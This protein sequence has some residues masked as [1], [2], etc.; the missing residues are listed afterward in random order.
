MFYQGGNGAL[1]AAPVSIAHLLGEPGAAVVKPSSMQNRFGVSF[2]G[3][4]WIPGL[5]KANPKQFVFVNVTGMRNINPQVLNGTVPTLAERGGDFSQLLST[6]GGVTSGQ[7]F[8]PTTGLPILNNNLKNATTP[9]SPQAQALLNYYP[10][11]N[12]PG[13]GPRNNYQ[14]V[15]NAGQNSTSAALRFVRNF[16]QTSGFG[17]GGGGGGRR[18]AANAPKT[19]RQ[20]INFNGSY[21][22]AASDIRNIFLPLGGGSVSNGYGVTA[23]YTIG[24][25]RLTNNAS[26]NWNRSHAQ[27]R[28]Y[29]TDGASDP[30]DATGISIPKPV[31]GAEP[32]IFYGIPSLTIASFTGLNQTV[33]NDTINQT[34]SF[35]D[36]VSYGY[37]KHNMRF[38]L[39]FR[40]VHADSIGGNNGTGSFTFTGYATQNPAAA[41]TTDNH[42]VRSERVSICRHAARPA[43]AVGDPGGGE[44]DVPA[45]EYLRL[46]CAG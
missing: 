28:N 6:T 39:D 33:A 32:G 16:G 21:S 20:N 40:R 22:H 44:Q 10:A 34:I 31:I 14:T 9:L 29:F 8:D 18:Q 11:P 38:G 45:C 7:L 15:T 30:L 43:A 27:Q 42:I 19:L 3:S 25:G 46:V 36:F 5:Y 4:P 13:S 2:T 41:C 17:R 23:G 1:N 35:S 37:K 24:Y 26:I 12:V